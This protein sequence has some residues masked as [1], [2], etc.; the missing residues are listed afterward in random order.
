MM[1]AAEHVQQKQ[2]EVY[3]GAGN[4]IDVKQNE[5]LSA[6]DTKKTARTKANYRG[7]RADQG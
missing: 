7:R 1:H 4:K 3:D 2:T 6:K 5:S